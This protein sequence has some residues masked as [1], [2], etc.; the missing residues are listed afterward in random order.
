M[1]K[2]MWP[3]FID[4]Y[5]TESGQKIERLLSRRGIIGLLEAFEEWLVEQGHM[6][7]EPRD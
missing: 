1:R 2:L 6:E 7:P 3:R 5:Q 4:D